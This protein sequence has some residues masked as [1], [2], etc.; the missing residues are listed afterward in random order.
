MKLIVDPCLELK[1]RLGQPPLTMYVTDSGELA[2]ALR[3]FGD[4]NEVYF[5]S[6]AVSDDYM[7]VIGG[8]ISE[9]RL[10]SQNI[11]LITEGT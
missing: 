9:D 5:H 2:L 7:K 11:F 3:S 10:R 4:C 1:H 6:C 8:G